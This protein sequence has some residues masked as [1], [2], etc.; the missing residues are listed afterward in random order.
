MNLGEPIIHIQIV[1]G[2]PKMGQYLSKKFNN[3]SKK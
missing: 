1:S 3:L 2:S